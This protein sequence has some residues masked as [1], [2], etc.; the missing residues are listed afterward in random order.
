MALNQ[1]LSPV[2]FYYKAGF[3]FKFEENNKWMEDYLNG[4]KK[5]FPDSGFMY[6]STQNAQKLMEKS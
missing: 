1:G 5:D 4:S 2:P 6:L 3:R